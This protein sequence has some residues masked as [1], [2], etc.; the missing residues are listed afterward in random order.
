MLAPR[1]DCWAASSK[2]SQAGAVHGAGALRGA[3]AWL[4]QSKKE[5]T[6]EPQSSRWHHSPLHIFVPNTLYMV[7]AST[8][9]KRHVFRG[10]DRLQLL[11]DTLLEAALA[12]GWL[13]QAWAMFSNHYHFI[14][15]SSDDATTLKKMIQHLHSQT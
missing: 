7:T 1:P 3:E 8:L 5:G 6:V 4:P 13:L 9:Y 10:D 15:Q 2:S 14:A 11:R 12:Y